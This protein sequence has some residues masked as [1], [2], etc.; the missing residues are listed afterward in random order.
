VNPLCELC[1]TPE[2][3]A[4][5]DLQMKMETNDNLCRIS[6]LLVSEI[7]NS[8]LG[9]PST[10]KLCPALPLA[11]IKL[12]SSTRPIE[13][14]PSMDSLVEYFTCPSSTSKFLC[15]STFGIPVPVNFRSIPRLRAF[16]AF[17]KRAQK[18]RKVILN[19]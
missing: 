6:A 16:P 4:A 14:K 8:V 1:T 5:K 12:E 7:N 18:K 17:R 3:P 13:K 2:R 19:F 10:S 9:S 15:G 11:K